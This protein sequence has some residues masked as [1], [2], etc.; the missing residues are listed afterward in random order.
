MENNVENS[1]FV[2]QTPNNIRYSGVESQPTINQQ[3]ISMVQQPVQVSY[4]TVQ[5]PVVQQSVA[6]FQTMQQQ[7]QS[8]S[9]LYDYTGLSILK[10]ARI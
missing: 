5:Q 9:N 6:P 7:P 2:G 10:M 1:S 3:G 8:S 4:Q